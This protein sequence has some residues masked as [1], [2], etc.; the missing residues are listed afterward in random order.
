MQNVSLQNVSR[1]KF[2]L[3]FR[4]SYSDLWRI[5]NFF[6]ESLQI[7]KKSSTLCLNSD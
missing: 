1:E 3:E 5:K 2:N 6:I 4:Y 7:C